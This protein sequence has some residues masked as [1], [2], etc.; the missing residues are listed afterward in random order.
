[1][2][3]QMLKFEKYWSEFSVALA[4]AVIFDPHYKLQFVDFSYKM[5]YG[6]HCSHEFLTAREK[7]FSLW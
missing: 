3:T 5:L 2:A 7:L 4:I 6:N 1:M